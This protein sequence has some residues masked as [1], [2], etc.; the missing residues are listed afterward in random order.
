MFKG[1]KKFFK[2][3]GPGVITGAADDDPSGIATYTQTGA[4]FGYGQLWTA[5]T[6]LP[7]MVSIQEACAR[8]GA[9]TGK[10]IAAVI[11]ENYNKKVLYFT[12]CL[13]VVANT[14]NIGADL[15]AMGAAAQLIIPVNFALL[16]ILF[17]V[18]ILLLEI[19]TS[20]KSYARILKWL[21]LSL[22]SYPLTVFI[23]KQPWDVLLR[24]TFVPHIEF[25]FAFLFIITGVLGTTISPYM[26][27]WQASEEVEEEKEKHL[28]RHGRPHIGKRF[29]RNL[30]LD[31]FFGMLSSNLATWCIIVVAATVL[32]SNGITNVGTA[33]EAAKALEPLVNTFPNA[34]FLAKM[35]F[36]VGVIGLGLL[37]V[38]ILSAS[39]SYALSEALSWHEGLNLKLKKAHGFYGVI[40][41]ATLIGLLINFIGL[42]PIKALVF[43]AVFN[44]VAAVPL[45]FIIAQLARNQKIMGQYKSG[46]FSQVFVGATFV[47]MATSAVAM[48]YTLAMG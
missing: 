2:A 5:V 7:F 6:M 27:F 43:A 22:L 40:T 35:I 46:V 13:V 41:I 36:A 10:G 39:A 9:V 32:N 26:F 20:Y 11:K 19:F 3:A 48:F 15:G 29:I 33:A 28:L 25:S 12:L 17:T 18:I 47:L 34:G 42:D 44:G 21:T 30:R 14:I 23:V 4:Q 16:T 24:A 45:I 37:A 1:L 8:I 38:P 31:N